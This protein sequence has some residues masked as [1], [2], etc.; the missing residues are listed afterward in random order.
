VGIRWS[1]IKSMSDEVIWGRGLY[2][3]RLCPWF[4]VEYK[5]SE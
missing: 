4:V 5:Y 1:E 3:D 2:K